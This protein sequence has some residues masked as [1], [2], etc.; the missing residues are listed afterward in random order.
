ML[1]KHGAE[2]LL[3]SALT[4]SSVLIVGIGYEGGDAMRNA[5]V[6]AGQYGD[7]LEIVQPRHAQQ[8]PREPRNEAA[9]VAPPPAPQPAQQ[10]VQPPQ[11]R[12]AV[13]REGP[14][15]LRID[16]NAPVVPAREE[17]NHRAPPPIANPRG[18]AGHRA[19][20]I[21]GA[22]NLRIRGPRAARRVH[23]DDAE[24]PPHR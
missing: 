9:Q 17:A 12:P 16:G 18:N 19:A 8:G 4:D 24:L 2:L 13:A 3:Y 14:L 10:P 7:H 1:P 11:A 20:R 21:G 22:G 23:N 5:N 15:I 6:P